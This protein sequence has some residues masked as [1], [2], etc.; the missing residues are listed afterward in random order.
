MKRFANTI[1]S[2]FVVIIINSGSLFAQCSFLSGNSSENFSTS[3]LCAPVTVSWDIEYSFIAPQNVSRVFFRFEWNDPA[4]TIQDVPANCT[5]LDCMPSSGTQFFTYPSTGI[6][7]EYFPKV[8]LAY[9]D[10]GNGSIELNELCASSERNKSIRSWASDNT[11]TGLLGV[12]PSNTEQCVGE[13]LSN[14]QIQDITI[15]NC[16]SVSLSNPNQLT[17]WV[18]FVYGDQNASSPQI[19][20]VSID[21]GGGTVQLTDN[22]GN[23]IAPFYGPIV[24]I[25]PLVSIADLNEISYPLSF[26]SNTTIGESFKIFLRNWNTCNP[27]DSLPF[28]GLPPNDPVNGDFAPETTASDIQIIGP[29]VAQAGVDQEICGTSTFLSANTAIV[30]TG[31]WL[32]ISGPSGLIINDPNSA[33]SAINITSSN[34]GTYLLEWRINLGS[35]IS[36]DNVEI[37]FNPSSTVPVCGPNQNICGLSTNLMANTIITGYG[38]WIQVGGPTGLSIADTS[39]PQSPIT[40]VNYGTYVLEWR[41]KNANCPELSDQIEITFDESPSNANAGIDI[42]ACGNTTTLN[43]AIPSVGSGIWTVIAS[44]Q[45]SNP[46]FTNIGSPSSNLQ[47]DSFGIYDLVWTV[48]NGVCNA[49]RDTVQVT[50]IQNPSLSNAGPNQDICGLSTTLSGNTPS[51]GQGNW[52]KISGPGGAIT[53]GTSSNDP[54]TTITVPGYGTYVFEWS[55]SNANCAVSSDQLTINFFEPPSTA[56]AGIDQQICGNNTVLNAGIVSVGS[57]IWSLLNSPSGSNPFIANPLNRNSVVLIDSFGTYTLTWTTSNGVCNTNSDTVNLDFYQ[58]PGIPVAGPD[59][60][61]CGQ[62]TTLQGNQPD[63]GMGTWVQVAGPSG[64]TINALNDPLTSISS[65]NYGTYVLEWRFS[66]TS[67]P[68]LTDQVQITFDASPTTA[69]AGPD[70]LICGTSTSLEALALSVGTGQWTVLSS[71]SGSNAA[72]SN[73]AAN[74]STLNIDSFGVYILKWTSSNGTCPSSEDNVKISFAEI[75]DYTVSS[76]TATRCFGNCDATL[77]LQGIKGTAPHFFNITGKEN[78]E[79]NTFSNLC[80]GNYQI[81]VTDKNG[82]Q[83]SGTI[84]IAEA[85]SIEAIPSVTNAT[86]G[87]NDGSINLSAFG[88]TGNLSF[89]WN[90]GVISQNINNLVSGLYV[91]TIRDQNNCIE[92]LS[93]AVND[94][95]GPSV[96]VNSVTNVTCHGNSDGAI[97]LAIGGNSTYLWSNGET[98][99]D[100]INL[101]AGPYFVRALDTTSNCKTFRLIN[102]TEPDPISVALSVNE[103]GCGLMDG[104]ASVLVSGGNGSNTINWSG[105]G[106]GSSVNGLSAGLHNVT[107]S[108]FKGCTLSKNFTISDEGAPLIFTDSI[109]NVN[110]GFNSGAIYIST[111]GNSFDHSYLWSNNDTTEDLINIPVGNYTLEVTDTVGCKG[112]YIQDVIQETSIIP[113]ICMVSVGVQDSGVYNRNN[114]VLWSKLSDPDA[115]DLFKIYRETTSAGVYQHIGSVSAKD[116]GIF[117]DSISNPFLKSY[118]YKISVVDTCGIESALSDHHKTIHLVQSIALASNTVNLLWDAYEGFAYS[119]FY[120]YRNSD[121]LGWELLDSLASNSFSYTDTPPF[122]ITDPNLFYSIE[123]N[124]PRDC[125]PNKGEDYTKTRSNPSTS[126]FSPPLIGMPDL[127]ENEFFKIYPNPTS[128]ILFIKN[129]HNVNEIAYRILDMRG[130][131]IQSSDYTEKG[132]NLKELSSGIYIIEINT[133]KIRLKMRFIKN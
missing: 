11:G 120:I 113:E 115:F 6:D 46:V 73:I 51:V 44:P 119:T 65:T 98:T 70:K 26:G 63:A 37:E 124:S 28:N 41:S 127:S 29:T 12:N 60:F 47:I 21:T 81:T 72:F 80:A 57:G 34:Y 3:S 52:T 88:G 59:Q 33:N 17:R 5:G 64:L 25:P 109:V 48:S 27:Y 126:I 7:C 97:D 69:D 20:N 4:N 85:D 31:Q 50:F 125:D 75:P 102:V 24:E 78:L 38:Y 112:F 74:N 104:T 96:N 108:D 123:V 36:T 14:F 42:S 84:N 91:A 76:Q 32:Q 9:D 55:I 94:I 132:I 116:P 53:Y 95:G 2:L 87:L 66:N 77:S 40:A 19:P 106:M 18:Q 58:S 118:R 111:T 86:C 131:L 133:D 122:S 100:I 45:N 71:P 83:N 15:P 30:G 22:N 130:L 92:L 13:A 89:Q 101:Q 68:T 54:Q 93:V 121:S 16:G 114:T 99:E 8:T 129:N 117:V 56:D 79:G 10:N 49:S 105:G 103:P 35:C 90:N 1:F 128:E 62:N 110:C 39:N 61:V 107:V 43:G 23:L 82:C 67:C